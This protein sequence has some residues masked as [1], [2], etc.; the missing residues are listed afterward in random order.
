MM[1]KEHFDNIASVYDYYK[2]KNWYYYSIIKKLSRQL[3]PRPEDKRILEI[4]CGTGE[5]LN[6]LNPQRG[7]GVD[8]SP[9]MIETARRKYQSMK[10]LEFMVGDV[11]NLRVKEVFD[12]ILLIDV[13]EHLSSVE[14]AI[15][16]VRSLCGPTTSVV[17]I[18]GNPLWEPVLYI[19]E[20]LNLK[21]P[22]GPHHR[23]PLK[24]LKKILEKS[25]FRIVKEGCS[26]ITPHYTPLSDVLNGVF[27]K[28]PLI[29]RMGLN[30]YFVAEPVS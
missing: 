7:L 2:N 25:G 20:R 22:E 12:A 3:I 23:I 5:L 18:Y 28:M 15:E 17:I 29:R 27:N 9:K 1:Q 30:C 10:N 11:E 21:M 4:G 19:A 13:V 26:T 14:K 24:T 16:N 8:I 6:F